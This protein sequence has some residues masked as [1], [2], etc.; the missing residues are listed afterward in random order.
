MNDLNAVFSHIDDFCQTFLPPWEGHLISSS[1][2][3]S[4]KPSPLSVS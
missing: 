4:N 3:Q 2:K 1:I